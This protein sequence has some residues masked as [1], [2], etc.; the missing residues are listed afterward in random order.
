MPVSAAVFDDLRKAY[1]AGDLIVFVGSGASAAGGL[2]DWAKLAT[3]LRARLRR[4]GRTDDALSEM[5]SLVKSAQLIDAL[6]AAKGLLGQVEFNREIE[7][8]VDDTG[9]P[10]PEVTKAIAE[11][12]TNL[13]GVITTN[14]DRFLERAFGGEWEPVTSPNADLVRRRGGYILKL[15]G[16]RSER[17][18]WVFTRDQYDFATF[19]HL[20]QRSVFETL[21]RAFPIL[22]VGYGLVDDDFN[23]TLAATR[24]LAG[25]HPPQHFALLKGPIGDVKRR[26]IE[27]A[28]VRLLIFDQFE[29]LP[30]IL[31]EV[32]GDA[33]PGRP[34]IPG[35]YQQLHEA[36]RAIAS[37]VRT[38]EF[39]TLVRDRTQSFVGRDYVF[40]AIT[41]ALSDS[42][43]SSG[44]VVIQGEPGIGKTSLIAELASRHGHVHHFNIASQ[45]IRSTGD[46]LASICAQLIVKYGLPYDEL[47]SQARIDGGFLLRVLNEISKAHPEN[48]VVVLVDSLDESDF[49]PRGIGNPLLL[50]RALPPGVYFIVTSRERVA[51]RLL[52]D[53]REDIYL[54]DT[55]PENLD[56]VRRFAELQLAEHPGLDGEPSATRIVDVVV[57]RSDGNFMY[58][59]H[60]LRDIRR[61]RLELKDLDDPRKLPKGL[62][63]YYQTHWRLMRERDGDRFQTYYEPVVCMLATARKPVALEQIGE[64]TQLKL[65]Q[66]REV[67]RE[68][69]DFLNVD[70]GPDGESRYRIYHTSFQDFLREEVGLQK[71]NE[72]IADHALKRIGLLSRKPN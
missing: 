66:V 11:L 72:R 36:P 17:S 20:Q 48:K 50:P 46:F 64:W 40:R 35:I 69:A 16:T 68:W 30:S 59:V 65:T 32:A 26:K 18:T 5:D 6:S 22:F 13:R 3:T 56:D 19:G 41:G 51:E 14:L 9:R 60:V 62:R 10:I 70:L 24:A 44:Y 31:R 7:N 12:K 8:A 2:P 25:P 71:Y 42:E 28:G 37:H 58:V 29:E 15:H 23:L 67:V 21:F 57:D 43:F 53:R 33:L 45:N 47:P 27:N 39:E 55:D 54:R 38:A 4:E 49:D 52:V 34:P 63:A 1:A 61:G